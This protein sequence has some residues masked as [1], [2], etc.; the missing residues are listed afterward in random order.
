[1]RHNINAL[2]L[3]DRLQEL[4]GAQPDLVTMPLPASELA[5][6]GI[7]RLERIEIFLITGFTTRIL[8]L[9]IWP[10]D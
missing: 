7:A 1:L 6:D 10:L 8:R 9:L 2:L 5:F 4:T 3:D